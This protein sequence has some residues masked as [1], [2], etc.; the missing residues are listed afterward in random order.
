MEEAVKAWNQARN[1][2]EMGK[3]NTS[4]LSYESLTNKLGPLIQR[5][6]DLE[7]RNQFVEVSFYFSCSI[8]LNIPYFFR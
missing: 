1:F 8:S 2:A 7:T 6:K 5:E 4:I 3:Y